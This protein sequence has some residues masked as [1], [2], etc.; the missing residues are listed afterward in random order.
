[1]DVSQ[2]KFSS[3]VLVNLGDCYIH[4][5]NFHSNMTTMQ[6][7]VSYLRALCDLINI[8]THA[9]LKFYIKHNM[10]SQTDFV[11]SVGQFSYGVLMGDF[12]EKSPPSGLFPE[13]AIVFI[14]PRWCPLFPIIP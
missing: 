13:D 11:Y 10:C 3:L 2:N 6:Q 5:A 9:Y 1:M 7:I 14:F 4:H 8:A 12:L